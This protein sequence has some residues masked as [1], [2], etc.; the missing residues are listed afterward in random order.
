MPALPT[1][2]G[3]GLTILYCAIGVE[4]LGHHG[5]FEPAYA[6]FCCGP[7]DPDRFDGVISVI[8]VDHDPHVWARGLAHCSNNPQIL[9][10][11]EANLDLGGLKP[12]G[13]ILRHFG[14]IVL[15]PVHAVALE[16]TGRVSIYAVAEFPTEQRR[17]RHAEM[18]ALD[19]PK[20]DVD[21]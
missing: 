2:N 15:D 4:L 21:A 11:V 17:D 9:V 16:R 8:A 20:R 3:N 18:L 10:R 5:F 19:I 12:L 7:A 14:G 1:G 13:T 6:A